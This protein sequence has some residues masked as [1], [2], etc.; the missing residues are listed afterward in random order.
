[1]GLVGGISVPAQELT[2]IPFGSDWRYLDNGTDQGTSWRETGFNDSGW[3]L[4]AAELGYGD[5]TEATLLTYGSQAT[6]KY[7]TYYFRRA[8]PVSDPATYRFLS[9]RL[10]RDDGAVVYLNGN[11]VWRENMPAGVLNHLTPASNTVG[12]DDEGR[13]FERTVDA[14]GLWLTG[15]NVLAV[16]VHQ[17]TPGSS[18]LRFNLEAVGSTENRFLHTGGL[19]KYLDTGIDA[20]TAWRETGFDDSSWASGYAQLGYGDG[21]EATE[22][23]FGPD[24]GNKFITYY[25]RRSFSVDDHTLYPALKSRLLRDDGAV[26]YLNGTELRRDNMPTSAITYL[27][28]AASTVGGVDETVF[29]EA[30]HTGA[31]SLSNGTNVVAIELHQASGSS[32]DISLDFELTGFLEVPVAAV[33]RGPYLQR[34]APTGMVV[35]W[36]T[37]FATDSVVRYGAGPGAL[38]NMITEPSL[39]TEHVVEVTGL[40]P[41]TSYTYSVGDSAG[42]R[43]GDDTNY[44]FTT[45]PPPGTPRATRVWVLGDSGTANANAAA[46]R[47][48]FYAWHGGA[49]VDLW[50]M[51]G[52]NAYS[53]GTDLE[54]QDAVFNMYP[55]T[56]RNSVLWPTLGNHDGHSAD[57]ASQAGPYY[58]NFTLPRNGESGGL[59]SG[60][61]AYYSFDHANIHFVC[62]DSYETD[63][64]TN[65]PM[66][67]WLTA[68]LSATTQKWIIAFWHHPPYTKGSHDSDLESRHIEMR[69][70][71]LPIL[72]AAG[73]DLVLGGHSHAYERSYF[74]HGHYGFSTGFV[75][76]YA[77]NGGDGREDGDGVYNKGATNAAVYVVAGSSGKTSGGALNHPAMFISLNDLGSLVL[78]VNGNWLD[79]TF[80]GNTPTVKDY[81]TL[82]KAPGLYKL[83]VH[84]DGLGSVLPRGGWFESNTLVN[85]S[86]AASNFYAF[87]AWRG[88]LT[89]LA[90][91]AGLLMDADKTVTAEFAAVTV[92][93]GVPQW[94]LFEHGLGTND[95]DALTDQDEDGMLTWEE[96]HAGTLPG[97]SGDF[98]H[99]E[100]LASDST[101]GAARITW[102]AHT[103]HVYRIDT[104]NT[105][106]GEAGYTTLE[107][108]TGITVAADGP[109]SILDTNAANELRIYR[110]SVRRVPE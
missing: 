72:E 84:N 104:L 59:A 40:T 28:P 53:D 45:S 90:N 79:A 22:L 51:L 50:M 2:Y 6:N 93:Y 16:E 92:A 64:A 62:L 83:E 94:W 35:R 17:A 60:T 5:G 106:L 15:T 52:D 27:T 49:G 58:D 89:G 20:G 23:G 48:A 70:N 33:V 71:T 91:P 34:G 88:D 74:L 10:V 8:F 38:T 101:S 95:S 19:W 109:V 78:D 97:A 9:M 36:R 68:D 65:A 61:E 32:S 46:V 3:A 43:A 63:R 100:S 54:Y 56:L 105:N 66:H 80:I 31:L 29:L 76:A 96:F 103:Q 21:D 47:D 42:A 44:F 41:E 87:E 82:T 18:D 86:A 81:F 26:V 11:E 55:D 107:P 37:D 98:F 24:S 69:E 7:I 102:T 110:L 14:A 75:P 108:Y 39:T 99:V 25:F 73:V 12:G 1:M 77:V 4:G 13:A 67:Q 85:L 30:V 57:S